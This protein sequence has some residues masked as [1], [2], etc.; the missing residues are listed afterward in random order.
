MLLC[1]QAPQVRNGGR[2][3]LPLL[4]GDR[5]A[6]VLPGETAEQGVTRWLQAGGLVARIWM[7]TCYQD[8]SWARTPT[9]G[10]S[11]GL[12]IGSF[13]LLTAFGLD[14][15]SG[16]PRQNQWKPGYLL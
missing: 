3:S 13:G 12:L 16:H 6:G 9:Y 5:G 8:V 1:R 11:V 14:S 7:L 4:R 15:K 10:P 2:D